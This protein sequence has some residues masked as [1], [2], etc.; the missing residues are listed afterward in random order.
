MV[1]KKLYPSDLLWVA[2]GGIVGAI[3]REM[4]NYLIPG[5]ADGAMLLTA[6]MVEN[7]SGSFLIG[8]IFFL[9][10]KRAEK[11]RNLSLFMLTGLIGSY[12]TYSGFMLENF[13]FFG[14]SV[15]TMLI[16]L[17]SQ[18]FMGMAAVFAGIFVAKRILAGMK[19]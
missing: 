13:Y 16:Y 15:L 2:M 4:T 14:E 1:T 12:T 5:A 19:H 18:I 10:K 7:I 11:S 3:L 8:L 17:F 9:L 6:I